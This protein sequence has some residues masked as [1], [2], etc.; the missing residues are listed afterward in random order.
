MTLRKI[1]SV[2]VRNLRDERGWT[3]EELGRKSRLTAQYLSKIEKTEDVNITADN[4]EKISKGFG[5]SP[6]ELVSAT[7]QPVAPKESLEK[8][9]K[10]IQLLLGFRKE[11][12]KGKG[13]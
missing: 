7:R 4:I 1:I 5:I 2:N 10:A 11:V 9:E 8:L 13:V 3:L 12:T 6:A